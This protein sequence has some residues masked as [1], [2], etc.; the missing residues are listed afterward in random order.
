MSVEIT[1]VRCQDGSLRPVCEYDQDLVRTWKIGQAVKVK[2]TKVNARSL[3]HHKLYFGG[4]LKLAFDYWTPETGLITPSE[5][6][7]LHKFADWLEVKGGSTGSIR[8]ACAVFLSELSVSRAERIEC[9]T[10][11]LRALHRF[12]KVEAGY[13]EYEL[14][15]AGLRKH[16]LSI[17]FNSMKQEEFAEFYKSAFSAVWRLILSRT[18]ENEAQAQNAVDQLLQFG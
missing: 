10:K 9:P 5:K 11:S 13:F 7:T 8:R 6:G 2:A 12:V 17:N 15:P 18:F 16:A 14:T 1:L 4:L 3:Q